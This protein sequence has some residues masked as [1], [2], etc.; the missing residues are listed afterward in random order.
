MRKIDLIVVHCSATREGQELPPETLDRLH[1]ERGFRCTG[2]H[3]YLRRSGEVV[4]TRPVE[5]PGAHAKA[6]G[7]VMKEDL[8]FMDIQP[9]P[10]LPNSVKACIN[11][12]PIYR[13]PI[14]MLGYADTVTFPMY[15]RLA[16]VSM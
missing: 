14:P 3:Y 11:F 7:Y 6:S 2:Y 13:K 12:W 4:N 16:L 15:T 5:F 9:I 10:V 8:T 1:R